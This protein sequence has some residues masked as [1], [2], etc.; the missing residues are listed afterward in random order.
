M[1]STTTQFEKNVPP[2]ASPTI[3]PNDAN[4]EQGERCLERAD[5]AL[6]RGDYIEAKK[7]LTKAINLAPSLNE[8][9]IAIR[10]SNAI[11]EASDATTTSTNTTTTNTNTNSSNEQQEST[12]TS[13]SSQSTRTVPSP[14]TEN[15]T[16]RN[17]SSFNPGSTPKAGDGTSNS[18]QRSNGTSSSTSS[19][20][21]SSNAAY[22]PE[23]VKIVQ[24][25]K[26]AKDYYAVLGLERGNAQDSMKDSVKKAYM[27]LARSVHP[28]KNH[29]PGA[30][31]AFKRVSAAYTILVDDDKR[32]A[33]DRDGADE[34]VGSPGNGG[35]G[36]MRGGHYARYEQEISPEDIFNMFFN[37]GM[38]GGPLGGG[39]FVNGRPMNVRGFGRGG[40]GNGFGG[41]H[42]HHGGGTP[43][44]QDP[45][46]IRIM[47]FI[48]MLP[49]IILVLFSLM[50]MGST[51]QTYDKNSVFSLTHKNGY[52]EMLTKSFD[53]GHKTYSSGIAYY[54][55]PETKNYL[56]TNSFERYQVCTLCLLLFYY[57][58]DLFSLEY[59]FSLSRSKGKYKAWLRLS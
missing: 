58:Y 3:S 6:Q 55:K 35:F 12:R 37:N 7:F 9:K 44:Q 54:V 48:Q 49:L 41:I 50:S 39:I 1:S 30:E 11:R 17:T 2:S 13:G 40:F 53:D 32:A 26:K 45:S 42:P 29:A 16:S 24:D 4:A 52:R 23:Q 15:A 34:N 21:S 38:G 19:S 10:I 56:D 46:Q 8:H 25:I 20:S 36:G 47:Q 28:D 57:F 14:P 43:V 51:S 59:S 18:R 22:T 5:T 33:Y 27:K 31:E